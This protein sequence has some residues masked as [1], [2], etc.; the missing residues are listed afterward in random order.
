MS[1]PT[2]QELNKLLDKVKVDVFKGSNAAFLA[3]ILCSLEFVWD[4]DRPNTVGTDGVKLYWGPADFM[5]CTPG[6]RKSTLFHEL[7][8]VALLHFLR[9]GKR[10]HGVWNIACDYRINNNLRTDRYEVPNTW[11]VDPSLDDDGIMAEEQIYEQLMQNAIPMPTNPMGDMKQAQAIDVNKAVSAVVRAVQ[12]AEM[13]GQAGNL[14]GVIKETLNAFLQPVL[15]WRTIL[16]QWATDLQDEDYSWQKRN[17]RHQEFYMPSLVDQEGR[18]EHLVFFLDTSASITNPQVKR[19]VSEVKFIQEKLQP[20]KL[21]LV[22]FDTVIQHEREFMAGELLETLEIH[23][24][25]GTSLKPVREW[26]EEHQP[27]AAIVLSDLEC[28]P[29]QPLTHEIP[30]LWAKLPSNHS[31]TPSFGK[32]IIITED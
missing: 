20:A 15:P 16:H 24:R 22:Q 26:I 17:R 21:T 14:P 30:L 9:K 4:W 11:V 5:R 10:D 6:E 7:W 2:E 25:G 12:V 1:Q 18:L 13:T 19:C 3:S 23:G 27:T 8:H 29:M 28:T 32:V 31:H